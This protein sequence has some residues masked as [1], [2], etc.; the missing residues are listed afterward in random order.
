LSAAGDVLHELRAIGATIE[1]AGDRLVLR[2]G[3]KPVPVSVIRR[4]RGAKAELLALLTVTPGFA[5]VVP[6]AVGEPG[7][8]QTLRRPPRPGPSAQRRVP[9]LLLRVWSLCRLR[10]WCGPESWAA[11]A[12]VLRRAPPTRLLI[13]SDGRAPRG[14]VARAFL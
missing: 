14:F 3:P 6:L 2:A 12:L 10:L 5:R 4:V 1:P 11:R 13:V 8:E 7:L 9:S